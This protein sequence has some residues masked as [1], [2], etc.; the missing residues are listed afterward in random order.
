[1]NGRR[2]VDGG[3][4]MAARSV[5][6]A[7]RAEFTFTCSWA[8]LVRRRI[9]IIPRRFRLALSRKLLADVDQAYPLV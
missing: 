9:T 5:A 4:N 2:P 1:M 6:F 8:R 3:H 7:A